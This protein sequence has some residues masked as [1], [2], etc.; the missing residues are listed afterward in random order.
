MNQRGKSRQIVR[1]FQEK[2]NSTEDVKRKKKKREKQG[3]IERQ[4]DGGEDRFM[5]RERE[6]EK[7]MG[8]KNDRE[9]KNL[10][11]MKKEKVE[12]GKGGEQIKNIKRK[13]KIHMYEMKD[14]HLDVQ[15]GGEREIEIERRDVRK[16]AKEIERERDGKKI[17]FLGLLRAFWH[18]H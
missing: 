7:D 6:R 2:R 14:R 3:Q 11:K 16:T 17:T 15:I 18:S 10:R 9:K 1:Y 5:D 13:I 8:K 12:T 4:K